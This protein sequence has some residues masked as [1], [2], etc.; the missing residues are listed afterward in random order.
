MPP[1]YTNT[2]FEKARKLLR[3]NL[4]PAQRAEEKEHEWFTVEGGMTGWK[5]LVR[6]GGDYAHGGNM[7][8]RS[9]PMMGRG[10]CLY[11]QG[12]PIGDVA[13]T[14]KFWVENME[15]KCWLRAYR[16]LPQGFREAQ[17]AWAKKKESSG[18][19]VP[20]GKFGY[21]ADLARNDAIDIAN[22]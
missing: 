19:P 10:F 6:A 4:T 12:V 15:D 8:V 5:Y 14:L 21:L 7:E 20:P 11:P 2:A 17:A 22:Y 18:V 16:A 13:L 3:A 1:P 9:G